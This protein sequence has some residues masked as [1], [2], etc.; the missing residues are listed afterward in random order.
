MRHIPISSGIALLATTLAAGCSG[1][2]PA[3]TEYTL[4]IPLYA[5]RAS[6]GHLDNLGTH[7]SGDNEVLA[8][9]PG[10]PIPADSRAEGE[11]I[12]RI[13]DDGT[14]DFK[15]I[16][17]NIENITQSH[18]HCG[19]PGQNGPVRMFLYPVIG[20]TGAALPGGAGRHNGILASGTF[21]PA[22]VICPAANV[23]TNMPLLDAMRAGL[24]YANVH[25]S[26]GV[27]PTNQGPGDFPGGEIRGQVE[28]NGN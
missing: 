16:A 2:R 10:A 1:D 26:D 23:G 27:A 11:A 25:T 7:L 20:P 28:T 21:N 3:P 17:T 8:V 9:A 22:G 14:V 13:N 15:I 6:N 24:T 19:R 4:R 5:E 18:I 12:F